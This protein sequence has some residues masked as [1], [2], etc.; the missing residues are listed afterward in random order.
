M[1]IPA[2]L[3]EEIGI[4]Q[5][6][7]EGEEEWKEDVRESISGA[8]LLSGLYDLT[9]MR[10][11]YLNASL[12]LTE[13]DVQNLSPIFKDV[14]HL[15]PA[16]VAV[17]ENETPEFIEQSERYFEKLQKTGGSPEYMLLT[18]KNHYTV[19]RMLASRGNALIENILR[20]CGISD[21]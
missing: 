4:R 19:S 12:K 18:G 2:Q 17:G 15:P 10:E 9:R 7:F 20:L 3:W 1:G 14:R 11:S 13:D 6:P 21:V 16:I 5:A 8:V